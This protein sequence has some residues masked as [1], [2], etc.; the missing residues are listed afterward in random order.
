MRGADD[1]DEDVEDEVEMGKEAY[2]MF[3]LLFF[4]IISLMEYSILYARKCN[5]QISII[6]YL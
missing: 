5:L 3:W 6:C 4:Y 1:D 2:N